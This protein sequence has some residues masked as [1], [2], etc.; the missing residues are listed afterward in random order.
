M[1][2]YIYRYTIHAY[3]LLY[4]F[5]YSVFTESK[6]FFVLLR[7]ADNQALAELLLNTFFFFASIEL[8]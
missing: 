6:G 5:E 4:A 2:A 7:F 1:H 3:T 8:E